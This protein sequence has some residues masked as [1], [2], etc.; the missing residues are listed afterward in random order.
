VRLREIRL[1][2]FKSF[3]DPA[4]LKIAQGITGVVGPNGCGKSNI[5]EA[6]LWAMGE[7]APSAVRSSEM[8]EVIFAGG[9][10]RAARNAAEVSLVVSPDPDAAPSIPGLPA[11]EGDLEVTRRIQRGGGSVYRVNGNDVRARDVGRLFADAGGGARSCSLVRQ[12]RIG[13]LVNARPTARRKVIEDAAGVAGL[14]DRRHEVELRINAA[15]R[16]LEA[17]EAELAG[18]DRQI[19][20]LRR[21]AGRSRRYRKAADG[22][23]RAEAVLTYSSWRHAAETLGAV[24]SERAAAAAESARAAAVVTERDA[25]RAAAAEH[26]PGL[27][28]RAGEA[29]T[30]LARLRQEDVGLD[31]EQQTAAREAEDWRSRRE[32]LQG[33]LER[34]R[35]LAADARSALQRLSEGRPEI[36]GEGKEAEL[37]ERVSEAEARV[38]AGRQPLADA[39]RRVETVTRSLAAATA[40][41]TQLEARGKKARLDLASLAEEIDAVAVRRKQA[42][43]K[44]AACQ[45]AR[46]AAARRLAA[47]DQAAAAAEKGARNAEAARQ[48]VEALERKARAA[49]AEAA[50]RLAALEA[51]RQTLSGLLQLSA[52]D[53]APVLDQLRAED[54]FEVALGAAF[55]DGL[56][57]PEVRETPGSTGWIDLGDDFADPV[58][59]AAA[60]P[61]SDRVHAPGCLRRRLRQ[62]GVVPSDRG[63]AL[64][65]QLQP[66]Q[67]LVSPE[68][69]VWQWDG[70]HVASGEAGSEAARRVAARRRGAVLE[71][72]VPAARAQWEAQSARLDEAVAKRQDR[73]RTFRQARDA[74]RA[75][76]SQ[77]ADAA[78]RHAEAGSQLTLSQARL[79]DLAEGLDRMR[80]SRQQVESQLAAPE[81]VSGKEEAERKLGAALEAARAE[82]SA[83]RTQAEERRAE[84]ARLRDALERLAAEAAARDAEEAGWRQRQ[85]D[86]EMRCEALERRVE[87][88]DAA[89]AAARAKTS[90]QSERRARLAGLLTAATKQRD[91][92]DE[93]LAAAERAVQLAAGRLREAESRLGAARETVARLDERLQVAEE[94]ARETEAALADLLGVAAEMAAETLQ[95]DAETVPAPGECQAEVDR[96]RSKRDRLGPVNLRAD[97]ELASLERARQELAAERDDL[98][99]ALAAFRKAIDRINAEGRQRMRD[100]FA[101]VDRNF[102]ALFRKL[103]GDG[104]AASL[105][106]CNAEDPF[107]AGLEILARP[108]GKRSLALHQMSGGEKALT[109]VALIFALFLVNPAP[110]CVLDEVDAPLDDA[111]VERFCDLLRDIAART[112]TDFLVVTHHAVTIS[113]MDRLYGVTMAERGVS[114]L[115]SVDYEEAALRL[116]G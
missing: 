44:L 11:V 39:E 16:N 79:A 110:V 20:G 35:K 91:D 46:E 105:E 83:L 32:Q 22:L 82:A 51:E 74:Q 84:C 78:R 10:S 76:E 112:G 28:K 80:Q 87:A 102:Q 115:V 73:E 101:D 65:R 56:H 114:Q 23:R 14:Q 48:E 64:Q 111:N 9:G 92:E 68:G 1:R 50:R 15:G 49:Q 62:V 70:L 97:E 58:L 38:Q 116:T 96:L 5:V 41:R 106:L 85:A 17:V 94:R 2:G 12:N 108:P 55:G 13:E 42:E 109:A 103:F 33:D 71:K 77:H 88:A 66:G 45:A 31:A 90:S 107:E 54:G 98:V 89:L 81:E 30:A 47:A 72:E 53:D 57:L 104:A 21:E 60:A 6:V 40:E 99:A 4:D 24:R 52:A 36:P 25:A 27:R 26:V 113:R 67:S 3:A 19:A 69:E 37:R 59:P 75:A 86:A 8:D 29:A 34:E 7:S 43:G 95:L 63:A 18:L 61:L 93:A 100:A